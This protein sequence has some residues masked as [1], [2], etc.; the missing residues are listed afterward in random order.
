MDTQWAEKVTQETSGIAWLVDV[1]VG[2]RAFAAPGALLAAVAPAVMASSEGDTLR[3][4]ISA[5]WNIPSDLFFE[6]PFTI[7]A[8]LLGLDGVL[9]YFSRNRNV[10]GRRWFNVVLAVSLFVLTWWNTD[11]STTAHFIAAAA[12]FSTFIAVIGYTT[13]LGWF[14]QPVAAADDRTRE[15]DKVGAEVGA[16]FLGLLVLTLIGF[17]PLG[18]VSFFFFELFALVNF[19]LFYVQGLVQPF[20]YRSYE[21]PWAWLNSL[22]RFL[23]VMPSLAELEHDSP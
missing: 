13:L 18:I 10:F 19:A 7:A 23:Q 22:F 1:A 21:F 5:Y 6:W 8:V 3:G 11:D 17:W 14:G 12:F 16:A 20:P 4:S 9:S 15:Q 2:F